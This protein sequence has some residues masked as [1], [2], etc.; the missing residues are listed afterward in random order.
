M[1][2]PNDPFYGHGKAASMRQ[3]RAYAQ[4][5]NAMDYTDFTDS[6]TIK[7]SVKSV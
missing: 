6:N 5:K 1:A 7:K 2:K 3:N 4:Q